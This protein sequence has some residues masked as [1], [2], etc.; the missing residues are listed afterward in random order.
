MSTTFNVRGALI[1]IRALL[2]GPAG[3]RNVLLALDTGAT[4]SVVN[5]NV[6]DVIGYVPSLASARMTMATG[7]GLEV[8]PTLVIDRIDALGQHRRQFRVLCHTLPA[9]VRVEGILG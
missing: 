8:V 7:S 4:W 6:L 3:T 2:Y 9:A 5:Q 1:V